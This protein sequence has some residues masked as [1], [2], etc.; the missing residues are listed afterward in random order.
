MKRLLITG[1]GGQLAVTLAPIFRSGGWEVIEKTHRELDITKKNEIW[2]AIQT[3][4]PE[5]LI[6]TAAYNQVEKAETEEVLCHLVNSVAPRYLATICKSEEVR[7]VHYSTDFV[8]DGLVSRPYEETDTPHP[9][10]V[11]G[12][13][14][15]EG[16]KAVLEIG[17]NGLLLRTAGLYGKTVEG[18]GK[19]SFLTR[20]QQQATQREPIRVVDDLM[21]NPTC[22]FD[23]AKAT[24]QL[25]QNGASG[26][27]HAAATGSCTWFEF[28]K[29]AFS[30]L[31]I[32]VELVPISSQEYGAR[33]IR[34]TFSVLKNSRMEAQ[35]MNFFPSWEEG[36][37]RFLK[38]G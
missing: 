36:L 16:E 24:F 4:H 12:Q 14:K 10:N 32:S 35:G 18:H 2:N 1:A 8:F 9:L 38:M 5:C 11:Y 15:W 37:R 17:K 26:L 34:P 20:L 21:T 13:S 7:L 31:G 33:A 6:N 22:S 27:F 28:A 3:H 19:P 23:L 29:A 30:K 25:V